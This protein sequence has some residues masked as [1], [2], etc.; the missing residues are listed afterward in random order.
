MP[1]TRLPQLQG[2]T[3]ASPVLFLDFDGV[4]HP[5]DPYAVDAASKAN[6]FCWLPLL[7]SSLVE[8]PTVRIVVTS[9]WRYFSDD[10]QLRSHLGPLS[11]RFAGCT[12]LARGFTRANYIRQVVQQE[13][14]RY[15]CALDDDPSVFK[16]ARRE[17]GFVPCDPATGLSE[18][19]VI[20]AVDEWLFQLPR[21]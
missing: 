10:E 6:Q 4:T 12:G 18:P 7:T 15:W 21:Q 19:L 14:L 17:R 2:L 16:A 8:Y 13:A 3:P 1:T 20:S 9:D 11:S 5:Y